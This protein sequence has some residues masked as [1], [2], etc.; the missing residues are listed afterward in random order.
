MDKWKK[1]IGYNRIP[2]DRRTIS[3]PSYTIKTQH[4]LSK[5]KII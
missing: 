3:I 1:Y 4:L 5:K 2:L